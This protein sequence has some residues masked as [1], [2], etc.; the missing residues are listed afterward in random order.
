MFKNI[1][2]NKFNNID[3]LDSLGRVIEHYR[4]LY[5]IYTTNA[6]I[7]ATLPGSYYH[8]LNKSDFPVVGDWVKYERYNEDSKRSNKAR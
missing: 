2:L 6:E 7:L 4:D 1:G 3:D 5:K 8:N